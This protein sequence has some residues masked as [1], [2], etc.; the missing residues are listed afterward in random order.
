M[1]FEIFKASLLGALPVA[2]FTFLMLQW[3]VASGRIDAFKSGKDLQKQFKNRAKAKKA[4][5]KEIKLAKKEKRDPNPTITAC[6]REKDDVPHPPSR[7]VGDMFHNKVTSFGA[8]FYGTMAVLTY[9]LIEL[10]EIWQFLG[11]VFGPGSWFENIGLHLIIDFFI[12]S[13]MNFVSAFIWFSTL[14]KYLPVENGW[15]WLVAAYLGY[16]VGVKLTTQHGDNIWT[17][18]G[19]TWAELEEKLSSAFSETISK[20]YIKSPS[21]GGTP[22]S[23]ASTKNSDIK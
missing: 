5:E 7:M 10:I 19:T 23:E 8:G 11:K 14:P 4:A 21:K 22:K 16:L 12:N 18:L 9:V 6:I 20:S 15:V 2:A 1:I 3:S 13:I 17:K